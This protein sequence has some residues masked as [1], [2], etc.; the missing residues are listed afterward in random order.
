MKATNEIVNF[1]IFCRKNRKNKLYSDLFVRIT[2]RR[3]RSEFSLKKTIESK[4]WNSDTQQLQSK[5][6]EARQ[7]NSCLQNVKAKLQRIANHLEEKGEFITPNLIKTYYMGEGSNEKTLIALI[8][9]HQKKMQS[10]L[11]HGTLKNYKTTKTY[12]VEFLHQEFNN[13]DIYLK[14]IKYKFILDFEYFL[15]EK[16]TLSNNGIM[17]HLERFKKLM[18][19]AHT[20]EWIEKNPIKKFKL[21]FDSVDMGYLS[22]KELYKIQ[23]AE[24]KREPL[25]INRDI[26]IFSC[27]TGL[28]YIDVYNLTE[29]NLVAGIDG[30]KWISFKRKK[31]KTSVKVPLLDVAYDIVKKY[32]GHKKIK[33]TDKLLPVYSNQKTNQYI[34]EV[35]KTLKIKKKL[36]FHMARHTFA[37]TVTLANGMPIETVSKMLG[38]TKLATTQI[39]A[40]VIDSKIADD[41]S[42]LSNKYNN[43]DADYV[44]V[45]KKAN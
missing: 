44:D 26:F 14:Q 22:E 3:S 31:T 20:L 16:P 32:K 29:E 37:T 43:Q 12:L 17:K 10:S 2:V 23:Q 34:K 18:N 24:L 38:H 41:F 42:I 11:A 7:I 5:S 30:K 33:D 8:D 28:A 4:L 36:S 25:I 9:Y 40:R 27:Y 15:S 19:F 35:A 39:Y 13:S 45:T 6:I 21:K 1:L